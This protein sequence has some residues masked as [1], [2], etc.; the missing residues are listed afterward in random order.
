[1]K[2][3]PLHTDLYEFTTAVVW[4]HL[5]VHNN[6]SLSTGFFRH[7]P[8]HQWG[9]D[10]AIMNGGWSVIEALHQY[11][12]TEEDVTYLAT[13][14]DSKG[15]DLFDPKFLYEQLIKMDQSC[16]I[17]LVPDGTLLFPHEPMYR[18]TGPS[19]QVQLLESIL[20]SKINRHTH[21][22]TT[23]ARI[24]NAANGTPVI[25]FSLRRSPDENSVNDSIAMWIG[26]VN[27]TS[28]IAAG[29]FGK[30]PKDAIK[31]TFPHAGEMIG[32]PEKDFFMACAQCYPDNCILLVDTYDTI[33]G[34]KNSIEALTYAKNHD[35]SFYGIRL[36]SGD[37]AKLSVVA[38][39]ILDKHDL[40][41]AKI[42]MSDNL[43]EWK[44]TEIELL[45]AKDKAFCDGYGVGTNMVC[46][47][48]PA[49][50][51]VQKVTHDM[52]RKGVVKTSDP[53]KANLPGIYDTFRTIHTS[54][55]DLLYTTIHDIIAPPDSKTEGTKLLTYLFNPS[56]G[57]T[58]DIPSMI[59]AA[60]KLCTSSRE[61]AKCN[62]T[63]TIKV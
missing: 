37:L 32:V 63:I 34:I 3:T 45:K 59:D 44:I 16:L 62:H 2:T 10:Y 33:Q 43:D 61:L 8:F 6:I 27:G 7:A 24:V 39:K 18:I 53:S 30:L 47:A 28:N 40:H 50:G 20:L 58:T 55:D 29:R 11:K 26:G 31:G 52:N 41:D 22:T 46:P 21:I 17:T 57:L 54:E 9:G 42:I 60:R 38:R 1:M 15:N 35:S 51:G 19:Y 23:A 25:D 4:K 5:N 36:D 12:F 56:K 14:V 49:L 48:D 13:L